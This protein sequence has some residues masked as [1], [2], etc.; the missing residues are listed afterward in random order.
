MLQRKNNSTITFG[1]RSEV[2]SYFPSA[3]KPQSSVAL[4]SPESQIICGNL[5]NECWDSLKM[6]TIG[7]IFNEKEEGSV[8]MRY[9]NP[10][11]KSLRCEINERGTGIL[12]KG[13]NRA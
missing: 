8:F 7:R 3:E 9:C 1:K 6:I 12:L 5:A 4:K 2:N 13:T 11:K 10:F